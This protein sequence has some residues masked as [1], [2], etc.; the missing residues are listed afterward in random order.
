MT[1]AQPHGFATAVPANQL[2][3]P[4][5]DRPY[6]PAVQA[7]KHSFQLEVR[8]GGA[9]GRCEELSLTAQ[10]APL[11]SPDALSETLSL[12]SF[13]SGSIRKQFGGGT[14][15]TGSIGGHRRLALNQAMRMDPIRQSPLCRSSTP[16]P[17]RLERTASLCNN[18]QD[19]SWHGDL[20]QQRGST[21]NATTASDVCIDVSSHLPSEGESSKVAMVDPTSPKLVCQT[22]AE[23]H[24]NVDSPTVVQRFAAGSSSES[25]NQLKEDAEDAV[26][27]TTPSEL[28]LPSSVLSDRVSVVDSDDGCQYLHDAYVGHYSQAGRG[29]PHGFS[30]CKSPSCS[31]AIIQR[32]TIADAQSVVSQPLDSDSC[33]TQTVDTDDTDG[34]TVDTD[35]VS[36]NHKSANHPDAAS[37][38]ETVLSD[39]NMQLRAGDTGNTDDDVHNFVNLKNSKRETIVGSE[40]S[41]FG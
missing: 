31:N 22:V 3:A 26:Q 6:G 36:R 39:S 40:Y 41:S 19:C 20:L 25:G 5:R 28:L 27:S 29:Y 12:A 16:P 23:V 11:A 8:P 9:G 17:V 1:S 10:R 33:D 34:Q 2:S 30:M 15:S 32:V 35:D 18:A 7:L 24:H 38:E 13:G 37:V 21:M 14:A 4:V